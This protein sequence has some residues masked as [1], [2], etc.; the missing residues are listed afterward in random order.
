[1]LDFCFIFLMVFFSAIGLRW[2]LN[3]I[4]ANRVQ[5]KETSESPFGAV[6]DSSEFE[7]NGLFRWVE[8]LA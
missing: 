5:I 6:N 2:Y 7:K 3:G 4:G 1:M 8:A